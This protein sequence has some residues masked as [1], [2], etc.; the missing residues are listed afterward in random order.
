MAH[1]RKM[2][3]DVCGVSSVKCGR[4]SERETGMAFLLGTGHVQGVKDAAT[5]IYTVN[6]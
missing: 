6:G 3:Q 1:G 2:L 4:C 5:W